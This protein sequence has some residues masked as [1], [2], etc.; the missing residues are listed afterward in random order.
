LR[1]GLELFGLGDLA[2]PLA[3]PADLVALAE[4]RQEAR[5]SRDFEAADR[6]RG[7][8]E[9]QGWEVRDVADGF[10]LVPK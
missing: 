8:I 4:R 9:D 10:E 3:A 7:E 1:W 5:A 2:E 6:L